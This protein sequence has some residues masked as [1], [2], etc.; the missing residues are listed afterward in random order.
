MRVMADAPM[1]RHHGGMNHTTTTRSHSPRAP[2]W[3]AWLARR[4]PAADARSTPAAGWDDSWWDSSH[5]LQAGTEVHI[6]A[7]SASEWEQLVHPVDAGS[8]AG[9]NKV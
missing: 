4:P 9:S 6:R 1:R 8:G 2:R 5:A 3:L 7:L